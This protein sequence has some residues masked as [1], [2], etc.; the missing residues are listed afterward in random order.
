MSGTH[1]KLEMDKCTGLGRI[2]T[3]NMVPSYELVLTKFGS[4]QRRHSRTFM[5][6]LSE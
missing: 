4:T 6:R 2:F 5:V 3:E 1:Y